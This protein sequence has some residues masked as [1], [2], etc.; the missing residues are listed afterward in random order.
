MSCCS[1]HGHE[2]D[3]RADLASATGITTVYSVTGMTCAH[4]EQSIGAAVSTVPGVSAVKVDAA[5]GLVTVVS[6]VEP[7]DA[8]IGAAVSSAGAYS[9]YGR[10]STA[11][12]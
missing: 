2:S 11:A 1:S 8:A 7:I 4:C 6:T 5:T 10:A 12:Y 3:D 9:L